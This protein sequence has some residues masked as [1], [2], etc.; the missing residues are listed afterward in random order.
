M[1][2]INISYLQV[3]LLL[4]L[5]THKKNMTFYVI[6]EKYPNYIFLKFI[7]LIN[8]FSLNNYKISSI[9]KFRNNFLGI[10]DQDSMDEMNKYLDNLFNNSLRTGGQFFIE[11]NLYSILWQSV[12]IDKIFNYYFFLENFDKEEFKYFSFIFK[13]LCKVRLCEKIFFIRF[14]ILKS[15]VKYFLFFIKNI[16]IEKIKNIYSESKMSNYFN[17]SSLILHSFSK[18]NKV[19]EQDFIF[20]AINLFAKDYRVEKIINYTNFVNLLIKNI[21][22]KIRLITA[23]KLINYL[24]IL[25]IKFIISFNFARETKHLIDKFIYLCLK[26]QK[27]K[28]QLRIFI[29]DPVDNNAIPIFYFL[30]EKGNNICFSSF[31]LGHYY[32]QA[33]SEYNGP[34]SCVLSSNEGFEE[35]VKRSLFKGPIENSKCYLSLANLKI[36]GTSNLLDNEDSFIKII[37]VERGDNWYREVSVFESM[38]F[39]S[40]LYQL[41]SGYENINIIIKK[42]KNVSYF[43]NYLASKFPNNKIQFSDAIRG[44][45]GDFENKDFILSHGISSLAIK[46]SELFNKPYIIFDKSDNSKNTWEIL[47]SKSKVKPIFVNSKNSISNIIMG[48]SR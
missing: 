33:F 25:I 17:F 37:V 21:S 14:T 47:Y 18:K 15:T 10:K 30:K 29:I 34:Y 48:S 7:S 6:Y 41:D 12:V 43:E 2:F 24:I 27:I 40:L 45:M 13:F 39:A 19:Q 11:N 8:F 44:Y 20:N 23:L 26:N 16:F 32:T 36:K 38:F 9:N 46:S 5:T 42:K 35:I 3:I 22:S 4:I 28:K 31:S 1:L